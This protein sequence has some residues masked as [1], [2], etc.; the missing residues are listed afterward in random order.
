MHQQSFLSCSLQG[1]AI[2]KT[3]THTHTHTFTGKNPKTFSQIDMKPVAPYKHG[4]GGFSAISS[5]A[6]VTSGRGGSGP[7][8]VPLAPGKNIGQFLFRKMSAST[9]D[10]SKA[11]C[12]LVTMFPAAEKMRSAG[13]DVAGT[14]YPSNLS[15]SWESVTIHLPPLQR[16]LASALHW[17]GKVPCN[18]R[19]NGV[20]VTKILRP[21]Q[22]LQGINCFCPFR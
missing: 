3:H 14:H 9:L 13:V 21:K 1:W 8:A 6:G 11:E 20:V 5:S 19:L 4:R 22:V 7:G 17:V 16:I 12:F 15:H 18:F 2:M 10:G